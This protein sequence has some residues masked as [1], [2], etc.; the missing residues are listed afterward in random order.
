M[1]DALHFVDE[2]IDALT[3]ETWVI[4]YNKYIPI[5]DVLRC[6]ISTDLDR[7]DRALSSAQSTTYLF[8]L[9]REIDRAL[10]ALVAAKQELEK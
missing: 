4:K 5:D 2:A 6:S 8:A 9:A 10:I 7:I 1:S 3:N